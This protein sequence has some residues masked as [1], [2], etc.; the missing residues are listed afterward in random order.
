M[1]Y[2]FGGLPGTGK[3]SLSSRLARHCRAVYLRIDTIEQAV[4]AAG[5]ALIGPEG[6]QAAFGLATDNL[7]LGNEVVADS[8][9]SIETTRAAW[10][11]AAGL[12]QRPYVEIEV[13][14]SDVDEHRTRIESRISDIAGLRLPTWQ[15][16]VNRDYEP[17]ITEHIVIDTAG[18]SRDQSF[19]ELI[20]G[21]RSKGLLRSRAPSL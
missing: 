19:A 13:I 17:W 10:R 3:S 15:D 8:V 18:R 6:Y 5:T 11:E 2:I 9:N 4:K 7:C 16:V 12:A 21:L 14:C 1:L 20:D